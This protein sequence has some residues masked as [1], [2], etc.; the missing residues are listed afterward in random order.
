[1][2]PDAALA[3]LRE[4]VALHLSAQHP[5]PDIDFLSPDVDRAMELIAALD[6]WCSSGGVL[7]REWG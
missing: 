3:E 2:D 5:Q 7:P 1:M 6:H 4:L